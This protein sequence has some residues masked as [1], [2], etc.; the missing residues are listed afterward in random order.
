VSSLDNRNR[1][2]IELDKVLGNQIANWDEDMNGVL[3]RPEGGGKLESEEISFP[4]SSYDGIKVQLNSFWASNRAKVIGDAINEQGIETIW[5]IGAGNG[6]TAIPLSLRGL[7]VVACEPIY[8]GA[9]SLSKHNIKTFNAS[10]AELQLPSASVGA[11]GMF[12]VLEHIEKVSEFLNE[13]HRV[14]QP[15]SKLFVTVPA[16]QWLFSDFDSSIGHFRRYSKKKLV[17][18]LAASGFKPLK[19]RY[20]FTSLVLPALLIR[21]IPYL[22][23]RR[24]TF[25]GEEGIKSDSEGQLVPHPIVNQVMN[26]VLSFDLKLKL[27][28]GLSLLGVFE[29]T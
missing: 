23:G 3:V 27:P 1:G 5:E 28:F 14:M 12:D 2:A 19:V 16:H 17:E 7:T 26:S 15:G 11:L 4:Q 10:L 24:K 20:F 29:P 9:L 22:L 21:R 25:E 8:Q 13:I 6:L 18:E